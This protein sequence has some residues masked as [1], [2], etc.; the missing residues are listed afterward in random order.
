MIVDG[1]WAGR[2]LVRDVTSGE[3][4]WEE[5]HPGEMIS[6]LT[7]TRDR[8]L[9]AY[10]RAISEGDRVVLRAWPFWKHPAVAVTVIRHC[11]SLALSDDGRHLAAAHRGALRTFDVAH[12]GCSA[13][14]SAVLDDMPLSGTHDS[15]SWTPDATAIA[16]AGAEV[17][18]T[19]DR[20]LRQ[21]HSSPLPYPCDVDFSPA[22]TLHERYGAASPIDDE[23]REQNDA[24][25]GQRPANPSRRV[26]VGRARRKPRRSR[27]DLA[28]ARWG[29]RAGRG[30]AGIADSGGSSCH[31]AARPRCQCRRS[32]ERRRQL[33]P[34]RS[35][36]VS[37]IPAGPGQRFVADAL[38]AWEG[39]HARGGR[40]LRRVQSRSGSGRRPDPHGVRGWDA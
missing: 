30:C 11:T 2:L 15:V 22:G 25:D 10:G 36:A 4:V 16:Y 7:C 34:R 37:P 27:S 12:D 35:S 8:R 32:A 29:W 19:F 20:A 3:V 9:W 6:A 18:Q 17:T 26:A 21:I 23:P 38:R 13:R 24:T 1:T 5:D 33:R 39:R 40:V 14:P 28:G 31:C